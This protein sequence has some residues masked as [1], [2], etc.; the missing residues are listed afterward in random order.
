MSHC[1]ERKL[2][3]TFLNL[4]VLVCH[5]IM[6]KLYYLCTK[7]IQKKIG[8]RNMGDR[9]FGDRNMRDRNIEGRNIPEK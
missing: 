8:D 6:P 2:S 3:R 7:R 5:C 4:L 1:L 9:N